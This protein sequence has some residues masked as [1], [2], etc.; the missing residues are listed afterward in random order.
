M[1]AGMVALFT[2]ALFVGTA[3]IA[4]WLYVRA[5]KLA[6]KSLVVRAACCLV[7]LQACSMVPIANT[8][9]LGLYA[10]VFGAVVPLLVA[11]WLTAFWLLRGLSD[12][13]FAHR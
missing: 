13:M 12:A 11:M 2:S 7:T 9:L 3:L 1:R 4:G 6:P 10:T 5:P 8:T